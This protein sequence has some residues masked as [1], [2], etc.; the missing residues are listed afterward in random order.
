VIKI[1]TISLKASELSV[2]G[3]ITPILFDDNFG[4]IGNSAGYAAVYEIVNFVDANS[5]LG[6][7]GTSSSWAK[8][9]IERASECRLSIF[10]KNNYN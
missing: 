9:S 10:I 5:S 8:E 3:L 4:F 6:E 1:A 7:L 2:R